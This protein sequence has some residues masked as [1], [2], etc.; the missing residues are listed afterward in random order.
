VR[1][2][3]QNRTIQITLIASNFL[4]TPSPS[5]HDRALVLNRVSS[6]RVKAK[7]PQSRFP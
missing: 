7:Q 2:L 5:L 4:D 1:L 6:S 3:G